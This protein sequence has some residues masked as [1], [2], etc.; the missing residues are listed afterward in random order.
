MIEEDGL[1]IA[2]GM[3][4]DALFSEASFVRVFLL[5]TWV[6]V[7][8]G[9]ILVKMSLVAGVAL[10]MKMPSEQR[11][12]G[13]KGMV[14]RNSSPISLRMAGFALPAITSFV[15]VV[16]LVTGVTVGG[17]VLKG[18]SE[19]ASFAFCRCVFAKQGEA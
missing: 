16:F 13:M 18:R 6:A 11:V 8:R 2:F 9:R 3:A 4:A 15:F 1:P 10:G 19:M 17:C 12:L 14:E 7:H 5:V